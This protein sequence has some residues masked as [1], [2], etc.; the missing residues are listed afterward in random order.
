M[1]A[2]THHRLVGLE[3]E[4]L[5]AFLALLGLLRALDKA[6]PEWRARVYW[7][8]T[9]PP[10]RPV[11]M[12]AAEQSEEAVA[13]VVAEGAAALA[14]A[15]CFDR[16][17][18]N[19][20][21]IEAR[22]LFGDA[23]DPLREELLDALMSDGATREDGSIWPTPL[24]FQ[25]GQ[26]HQH[27]LS[28]LADIPIG[29]LPAKLTRIRHPP[30]LNSPDHIAAALFTSWT[31]ND[32]TD[33][34]RW[35]PAEDRRYALRANDPS[36]NPAGMQHGANRLATVGIAAL[37]GA[38]VVRRGETRFLNTATSYRPDGRIQITWPIWTVP[39]RL[40]GIR[41]LLTHPALAA[42]ID[43]IS[44]TIGELAPLGVA[45]A[46]R[47]QRISVGKFFNVTPAER[48]G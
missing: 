41:A 40:H 28:R 3:P 14:V 7:D 10:L 15:H 44:E 45:F 37:A 23:E 5:L 13:T 43:E 42:N 16:K 11:L 33:G 27:F 21:G 31:R 34:L 26:G 9:R 48:V 22:K 2:S 6:Q 18:L 24:C 38:V 29:R 20:P 46:F 17:D 4:N 39:A 35:D 32:A 47:A 36:G 12:L 1:T 30:A 8:V 19:F 25:F